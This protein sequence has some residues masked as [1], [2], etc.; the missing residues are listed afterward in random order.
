[1]DKDAQLCIIR[2]CERSTSEFVHEKKTNSSVHCFSIGLTCLAFA[3]I[4]C[5]TNCTKTTAEFTHLN[6]SP[7]KNLLIV[8]HSNF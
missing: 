7:L 2:H 5:D 8:F 4:H 1:M 3:Q 6:K